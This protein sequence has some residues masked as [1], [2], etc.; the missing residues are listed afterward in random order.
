MTF[1][2]AVSMCAYQVHAINYINVVTY[3]NQGILLTQTVPL[4]K[5]S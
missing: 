1:L 2:L 5:S 4:Y 3:R